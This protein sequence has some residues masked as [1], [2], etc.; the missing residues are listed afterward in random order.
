MAGFDY[1]TEAELFPLV[2]RKFTRG[3]SVGY[4]W[5]GSGRRMESP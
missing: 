5:K 1:R 4:N 3:G 2:R